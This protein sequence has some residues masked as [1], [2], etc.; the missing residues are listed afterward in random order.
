MLFRSGTG[1]VWLYHVTGGEGVQLVKRANEQLQKELGEPIYAADGKSIFYTRNVSPGPIFEYAQNSRTDLFDIERYDIASGEVETAVSGVGG[2]VR[3][4][5]AHDGKRIAFVRREANKTKL[6]VKDFAS[7]VER[8]VYDDLDRDVQ[9]TWAVTGV[10]PNMAWTPDDKA[11]V[12]WADRKSTRLN[13]SH[14][15]ES[16]MPSSA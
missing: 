1:E 3:P 5:P 8:V 12:F 14:V 2:S 9:E 11:I 7:G 4:T 16:R 6:W 13:S 15:S 10:Y